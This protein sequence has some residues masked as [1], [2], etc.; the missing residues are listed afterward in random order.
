MEDD[1]VPAVNSLGWEVQT[2]LIKSNEAW[3]PAV[4]EVTGYT[5]DDKAIEKPLDPFKTRWEAK[6]FL[7]GMNAYPTDPRYE[8]RVYEVLKEKK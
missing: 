5:E 3:K 4:T 7:E 6:A 8:F 2:R 1:R